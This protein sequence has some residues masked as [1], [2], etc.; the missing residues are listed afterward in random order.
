MRSKWVNYQGY[1]IFYQDFSG[2][3]QLNSAAV[4]QELA[5]VQAVVLQQ[6]PHSLLVLADFRNTQ[7]GKE[8]MDRLTESS[9]LTQLHV[10]KT[11]VLGVTGPKRILAGMLASLTGQRFTMFDHQIQ[12]LDWLIE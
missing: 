1:P 11:A 10:K 5:A 6:P 2:H 7:I 12:A 3:D 8:L 4:L 9:R